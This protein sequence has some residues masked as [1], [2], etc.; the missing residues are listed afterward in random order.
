MMAVMLK[1]SSRELFF[2]KNV[3]RSGK[4]LQMMTYSAGSSNSYCVCVT[5]R[6]YAC[7]MGVAL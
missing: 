6:V 7:S 4:G 5:S 1:L 3:Q 2:H